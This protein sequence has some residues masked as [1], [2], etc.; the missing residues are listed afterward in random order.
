MEFGVN[1]VKES[2]KVGIVK[3]NL[4]LGIKGNRVSKIVVCGHFLRNPSSNVSELLHDGRWQYRAYLNMVLCFWKSMIQ[5]SREIKCGNIG[6]LA[7]FQ[8]QLIKSLWFFYIIV[9]GDKEHH[10]GMMSYLEWKMMCCFHL[11]R[12]CLKVIQYLPL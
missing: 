2:C 11:K 5:G 3:K 1:K 10:L 7:F 4:N 6:V 12:C 8:K 9:E